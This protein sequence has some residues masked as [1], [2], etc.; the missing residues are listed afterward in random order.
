MLGAKGAASHAN[1]ALAIHAID[2]PA[3]RLTLCIA[4]VID[5]GLSA[6]MPEAE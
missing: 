3:V 1:E 6:L 2:H 5:D 4:E